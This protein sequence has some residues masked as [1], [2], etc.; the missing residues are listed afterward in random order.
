MVFRITRIALALAICIVVSSCA[1][2]KWKKIPRA[3]PVR[4]PPADASKAKQGRKGRQVGTILMVNMDGNF[5]LIDSGGWQA[6]Q[7]GAA[8]KCFR[9]ET[10]TGVIAVGNERQGTHVV[11]DIITG[12]P[13]KGDRVLQ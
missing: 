6:P 12:D 3:T 2:P 10:E 9:G 7:P 5:V 8:L 11:A 4:F 1:L 13:R